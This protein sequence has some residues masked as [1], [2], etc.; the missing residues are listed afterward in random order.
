VTVRAEAAEDMNI[1]AVRDARSFDESGP[2]AQRLREK[3]R[4]EA[5][6]DLAKEGLDKE[7]KCK[8]P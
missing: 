6:G 5:K 2:Q 3:M 4:Q 7:P 1:E 8:P